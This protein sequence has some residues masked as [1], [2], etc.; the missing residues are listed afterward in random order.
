[1][2]KSRRGWILLAL[3][4]PTGLAVWTFAGNQSNP[5]IHQGNN[6]INLGGTGITTGNG[7]KT[8][9]DSGS[10][11]LSGTGG[12]SGGG[13]SA[14]SGAVGSGAPSGAAVTSGGTGETLAQ[15]TKT[16]NTTYTSAIAPCK[17]ADTAC[18][19]AAK[20]AKKALAA[21]AATLKSCE[22]APLATKNSTIATCNT[23]IKNCKAQANSSYTSAIRTLQQNE[24]SAIA[25]MEAAPGWASL[26]KADKNTQLKSMK[27]SYTALETNAAKTKTKDLSACN[28]AA[29][30]GGVSSAT[31]K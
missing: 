28:S 4:A 6:A 24:K 3:A 2:R 31:P 26:S 19:K 17:T 9:T 15:C 1:M 5:F 10:S 13:G 8:D 30:V 22:K 11:S 18:V 29:N 7:S 14:S 12:G 27:A 20:G 23:N 25:Q 21:C 16:A